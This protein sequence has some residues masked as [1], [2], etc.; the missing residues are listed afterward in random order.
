MATNT[1]VAL[2]TTTI[3]SA[4]ADYTFSSI[5]STYTDLVLVFS[6]TGSATSGY[7]MLVQ[8]N[9]DTT[10]LYSWTYLSGNGT[11]ASSGRESGVN[12]N[13][14]SA[15]TT[16]STQNN[17]ILQIMNYSNT[18]TYKTSI[19]RYNNPSSRTG[20][21]VNLWRKTEAISSIRVWCEASA[22]IAAGT[23][24]SLYGIA[25]ASVG[26]KATGGA[27]YSDS[28][29]YYHVFASS[30]TFTPVS[31]LSC[32]VLVVAGGGGGGDT[33]GGGGGAGGLLPFTSQSITTATTV[34][35]GAGGAG[36]VGYNNGT[37][38]NGTDSQFG[39]LTLVKGGGAG[40]N[41]STGAGVNG[42]TGGSGGGAATANGAGYAGGG[43]GGAGA[44]AVGA[45]GVATSTGIGGAGGVGSSAYSSWGLATGT[46]QLVSTTYYY[47]GGGAGGGNTGNSAGGA[48]GGGAG[49]SN[50]PASA[51]TAGTAHT[52]GG[53]GG[54]RDT[55][56]GSKG[57]SGIVIVRYLKV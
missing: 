13:V 18:T 5:P 25:A 45:N 20:A 1:Y 56:P 31:T 40:A 17:G 8:F 12:Y 29:Y 57:G 39:A 24:I 3:N 44:G 50:S 22:N 21:L 55:A 42:L 54:A 15:S 33:V 16:N 38:V 6:G 7:A 11:S 47:A 4:V 46:G 9:G 26:A 48:G 34:T 23:T 27:I 2:A 32:D 52:G 49:G 19:G 41:Y 30:G 35:V 14:I 36:G 43:G 10:N 37:G 51:A 28:D 53:G